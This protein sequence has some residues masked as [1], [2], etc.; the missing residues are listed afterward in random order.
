[1]NTKARLAPERRF[2]CDSIWRYTTA[3]FTTRSPLQGYTLSLLHRLLLLLALC[4]VISACS[5]TPDD[6]DETAG[7]TA[8]EIYAEAKQNLDNKDYEAA[9]KLYERLESRYPYGFYAEQAQLDVAYAYYKD[10]EPE[11]AILAAERFIKLHPNHSRVDYA[12]YMRGLAS[13]DSDQSLIN[14]IFR[15]N[16]DE[17]DPKSGRRAFAYFAELASRF[18]DSKY[19]P[20]AIQRM[21]N[22]RDGLADYEVFVIDY[23][24]QRKAYVAVVNRAKFVLENYQGTPAIPNALGS[25]VKGYHNLGLDDLANDA[26]QV[27]KINFPKHEI[28]R[29]LQDYLPQSKPVPANT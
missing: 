9:A 20:D 26:W 29:Q 19:T 8:E 22:I 27:L 13:Y 1:M 15:Q 28:T 10:N 23:Y 17:R 5:L 16:P 2:F 3:R 4:C 6:E 21:H 25:M 18:P 7:M 11:S 14:K 12:Y 24:M